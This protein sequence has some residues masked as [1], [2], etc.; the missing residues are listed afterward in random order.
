MAATQTTPEHFDILVLGSGEAGKYLAWTQA[1][2][3]GKKCAVVERQYIGG[4]CPNI[5]CLP[6]KNFIHSANVAHYARLAKQYGLSSHMADADHIE[7]DMRDVVARKSGMVTGLVEMHLGKFSSFGVQLIHG[8]GKFVGPKT[9]ETDIDHRVLSA[10]TVIVCTGS[11]ARIDESILGLVEAKPLTHVEILNLD[12]L[13]SH[14]IVLGGGYVGLEFAQAF[15]RFGSKVTIVERGDR[16]L[17]NEDEDIVEAL[18]KVLYEKEGIEFLVSTRVT[19][20][21]GI[22]GESVT[23]QIDE[24]TPHGTVQ[25]VLTG[26]HILAATGRIPNTSNIGLEV[27]GIKITKDGHIAV[28]DQLRTSALGVFAV[29][30]CAGSPHFTHIAFDDFRVINA[31]LSGNPRPLGTITRQVPSV[32]FTA[33]ELAHVGLHEHEAKERG[34]QYRIAKLP[35]AAILRTGTLG[36]TDGFMKVLLEAN[37]DRILGFTALGHGAG[38]LL[39]VVQLAMKLG[40]G[41]QVIGDLIITHPTMNEGLTGLF[42]AVPPRVS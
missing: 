41:Y 19:K 33:P 31:Y 4:S 16:M 18:V 40:V 29:G 30:D 15:R 27:A 3:Y 42:A 5:A 35:M 10:E 2:K 36:E 17:K 21:E 8:E 20:V 1:A 9:I 14:L 39:P 25:R 11:R 38:E 34:V 26:S 37:G 12:I 32:L 24:S 23:I 7:V 22:S 6:S 13:P 28:D